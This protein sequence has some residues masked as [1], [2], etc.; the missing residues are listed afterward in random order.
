MAMRKRVHQVVDDESDERHS[1]N[2][3]TRNITDDCASDIEDVHFNDLPLIKLVRSPLAG[4]TVNPNARRSGRNFS[5]HPSP[6]SGLPL[7][8][9]PSKLKEV[10]RWFDGISKDSAVPLAESKLTG[11]TSKS[12][13]LWLWGPPGCGKWSCIR[14]IS[15]DRRI[16]LVEYTETN[17][18][19]VTCK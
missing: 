19:Q 3:K 17:G 12:R 6:C 7:F 13:V 1:A 4:P 9:H 2:E 14:R 10:E 18:F 11:S 5:P 15:A 8:I 16:K